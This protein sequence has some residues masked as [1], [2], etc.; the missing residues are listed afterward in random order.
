MRWV[1]LFKNN[2]KNLGLTSMTAVDFWDVFAQ[3]RSKKNQDPFSKT[4]LDSF[5]VLQK[6][7]LDF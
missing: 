2:L 3:D 6:M 5:I 7:N 4:N 1:F